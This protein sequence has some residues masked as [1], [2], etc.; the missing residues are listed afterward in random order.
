VDDWNYFW[1]LG[2][3]S[4]VDGGGE[5]RKDITARLVHVSWPGEG[6]VECM[7]IEELEGSNISCERNSWDRDLLNRWRTPVYCVE[8][9]A[10]GSFITLTCRTWK[11]WE[12]CCVEAGVEL[13]TQTLPASR[14]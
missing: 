11:S 4:F 3:F 13:T 1:E 6:C 7:G 10:N 9:G 14:S 12:H 5:D 8:V 2:W